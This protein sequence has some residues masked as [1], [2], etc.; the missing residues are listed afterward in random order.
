[1]ANTP[2]RLMLVHVARAL[3]LAIRVLQFI[4]A[5]TSPDLV[6]ERKKAARSAPCERIYA[7]VCAPTYSPHYNTDTNA[8]I[9]LTTFIC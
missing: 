7:V 6:Y 8:S 2:I 1:M 5:R 4:D 3:T 9:R